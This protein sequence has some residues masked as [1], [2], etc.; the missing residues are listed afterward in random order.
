LSE[1]VEENLQGVRGIVNSFF[2]DGHWA[3]TALLQ[4][5]PNQKTLPSPYMAL[6]FVTKTP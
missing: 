1:K 6:V 5:T 2:L 3:N 4:P